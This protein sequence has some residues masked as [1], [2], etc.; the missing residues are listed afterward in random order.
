MRVRSVLF[1]AGLVAVA[2]VTTACSGFVDVASTPTPHA[3]DAS[4]T[5]GSAPGASQPADQVSAILVQPIHDAQVVL[6]SDEMNHVE[7]GLLVVNV[8]SDPVT[9]T[10]VT[11]IGPDGAELQEI[12][13]GDLAAA[14]QSL[15]T[16]APSP[17]VAASA[18]VSV[19]VD[20]ML[21][22]GDAPER[23]THRI[24]YTLP[25]GLPGGVIIDDQVVH[26]PEVVVDRRDAMVIAPPV[27]GDGWIATSACCSPN[28]HRDLRLSIDGLRIATAE[29]FAIDWALVKG[30][31]VYDG[32]GSSNE[33][34]Y[35]FGADVLA[36]ADGTV[37]SVNDGVQ[38]SIPFNS[39][40]PETKEGFGGNQVILEIAPD[41]YAAYGHLQPNSLTVAVGDAV[42]A[43]DVVGKLGNTGPSQGPHLHF[44]LLDK[45]DL[46]AGRSLPFVH[47]RFTLVGTVDFS[48][49]T[50]D[51]LLIS[52][53]SRELSA[54]YPLY[55]SI[56]NFP[57]R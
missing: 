37:V 49:L 8:F 27:A 42:E 4:E 21:P 57:D 2:S 54:A 39:T 15:Y 10:G 22:P 19:D 44:G 29:T 36:V 47:E 53:E 55:G 3:T 11:V 43:G 1:S 31:R 32:D 20:L 24:E 9:L 13:G 6:G 26:G 34:F 18:A 52:P 45:P 38:E 41:V 40:P 51:E 23:V 25:E 30:D 46:F 7:Y 48:A 35:D 56:V 28:V 33:Q 17:V 16:H 50:G 5:P 14:T 12:D